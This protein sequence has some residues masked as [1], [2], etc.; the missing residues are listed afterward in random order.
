MIIYYP[1][2]SFEHTILKNYCVKYSQ[3]GKRLLGSFLEQEM[4]Y[5][6]LLILRK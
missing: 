4:F 3:N 6:V 1:T 5:T 2:N